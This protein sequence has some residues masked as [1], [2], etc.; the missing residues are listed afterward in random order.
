MTY[1]V[2]QNLQGN[3]DEKNTTGM[4]VSKM[5]VYDLIYDSKRSCNVITIVKSKK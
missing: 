4:T 2:E 3:K 1:D 5:T